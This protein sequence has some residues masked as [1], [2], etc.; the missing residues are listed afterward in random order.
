MAGQIIMQGFVGFHIPLWFGAWRRCRRR[1]SSSPVAP[2][3]RT[4]WF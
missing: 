3:R 4:R 2:M 1:S